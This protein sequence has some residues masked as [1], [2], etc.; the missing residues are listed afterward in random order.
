MCMFFFRTACLS[1]LFVVSL[2]WHPDSKAVDLAPS[3]LAAS[4]ERQLLSLDQR[5]ESNHALLAQT[6][7]GRAHV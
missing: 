7:I 2:A 6:E 4:D 1:L 5:G 3:E